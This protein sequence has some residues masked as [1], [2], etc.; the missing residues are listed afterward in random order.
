V[1]AI[2]AQDAIDPVYFTDKTYYLLPDGKVGQRPYALI[3]QCLA[4]EETQAVGQVV[5]FGREELVVVRPVDRVLEMTA[6]K[7]EQEVNHSD[8]LEE[9]LETP[10]LKKEEI[11]LTKTLLAAFLRKDFS[12]A[13]FKDHYVEKLTELIEAKAQGKEISSPP[14]TEEP[15]V[16]NLMD[17]MQKSVAAAGKGGE[18]KTSKKAAP[19]QTAAARNGKRP[20]PRRRTG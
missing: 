5:L 10:E 4:D 2:V 19:R 6:L 3:Q 17:A 18:R 8:G 1:Q 16:I 13:E 12:M 20:K 9:E 14:P 15:Q 7:Y 11:S